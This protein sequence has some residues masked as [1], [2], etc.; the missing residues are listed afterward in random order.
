MANLE[1]IGEVFSTDV[2]ILGGG[3]AGLIAANKIKEL[4]GEFDVLIVEKATTGFSGSK[5]NKGA[6]VLWVMQEGDDIDKFR[7]YFVKEIVLGDRLILAGDVDLGM[8][9]TF[10]ALAAQQ[11]TPAIQYIYPTEGPILWQDNWV[12]LNGAA[13]A[14]AAYAWL[15]YTMQGDVFWLTLIDYTY[16]NPNKA[17]L[18]FAKANHPDVYNAY[19]DSPITNRS[20]ERRVGKECRS[21]WSPYH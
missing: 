18:E 10:E 19:A 21:R 14:D 6:G 15:N 13:H 17:A 11:E 7:D 20:E 5:A 3:L 9:W 4:N 12:M 8:T 1:N 2:L 16:T